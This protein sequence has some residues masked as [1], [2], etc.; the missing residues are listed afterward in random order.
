M[1]NC[2]THGVRGVLLPIS[3]QTLKVI[4]ICAILVSN[5]LLAPSGHA[6]SD[7]PNKPVTLVLAFLPGGVI[8]SVGRKLADRLRPVLKQPIIAEN[9]GGAG[10]NVAAA[11][12]ARQ[13]PAD[14]YTIMLT[15]YDGLAIAQAAKLNIGFEPMRDLTPVALVGQ[16]TTLLVV[17][18]KLP[19]KSFQD[20]LAYAKAQSAP[21]S[22]GSM[23]VGSPFHLAIERIMAGTGVSFTHVPYKGVSNLLLDLVAGRLDF[24]IATSGILTG[25]VAK[26]NMR[27]VAVGD[28]KRS[29][30]FPDVPT[31][32]ESGLPGFSLPIGVAVFAPAGTP[33]SVVSRLN[34]EINEITRDAKMKARLLEDGLVTVQESSKDLAKRMRGDV[35]QMEQLIRQQNLKLE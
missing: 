34:S 10:G 26:G 2:V 11:Y 30:L 22:Y 13:A 14:G 28:A 32:A 24:T 25:H 35:E 19:L 23:G 4:G 20:L 31:V 1:S 9:R 7:Y 6:Q 21:L 16:N 18:S 27:V 33:E 5:L 17:N 3:N 8:D 12:L 29:P 15:I